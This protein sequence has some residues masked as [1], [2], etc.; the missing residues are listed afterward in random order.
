V[1]GNLTGSKKEEV[2]SLFSKLR[3][4]GVDDG[5]NKRPYQA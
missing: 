3:E 5:R 1:R 2:F 4:E